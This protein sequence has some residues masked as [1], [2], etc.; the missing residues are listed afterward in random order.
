[1]LLAGIPILDAVTGLDQITKPRVFFIGLP[2]K[3]RR[4]T[5]SWARAIVLEER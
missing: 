5:A 4:V 1:M 3:M 2:I